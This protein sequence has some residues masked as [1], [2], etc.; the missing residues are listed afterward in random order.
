MKKALIVLSA[1]VLAAA[2]RVTVAAPQVSDPIPP[3]LVGWWHFN[4]WFNY[5]EEEPPPAYDSSVYGNDATIACGARF[6]PG[7]DGNAL[8]LNLENDGTPHSMGSYARIPYSESLNITGPYT[9]EAYLLI[10]DLPDLLVDPLNP[11]D[12]NCYRPIFLNGAYYGS[13]EDAEHSIEIYVKGSEALI[14]GHNRRT[15][16]PFGEVWFPCPPI[17][18]G[19]F[20][21]LMIIFDGTTVRAFYDGVEQ[22]VIGENNTIPTPSGSTLQW[23]I[24]RLLDH[25]FPNPDGDH[26]QSYF[27]GLIDELRIW[28]TAPPIVNVINKLRDLIEPDSK[29]ADKLEDVV[30]KLEEAFEEFYKIPPDYQAEL[31]KIE[32]AIGDI[33]KAINKGYFDFETGSQLMDQLAQAA[34]QP[35]EVAIA[36]AI[37]HSGDAEKIAE[38]QFYL[39]EG[40]IFRSAGMFK[41]AVDKYKDALAKAESSLN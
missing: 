3:E 31:K 27:C 23:W 12:Q 37:I 8:A 21:H 9:L 25:Q 19:E 4:E 10:K 22:S 35:A 38:A 1:I 39:A 15:A 5:G 28:N 33:E 36:E 24:G 29:A 13:D 41:M 34:R 32:D 40:D 14:V 11:L 16:G 6:L 2:I 26:I 17:D 20:F 30:A 18:T 7:I